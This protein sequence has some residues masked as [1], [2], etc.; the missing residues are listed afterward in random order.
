VRPPARGLQG[1]VDA[2]WRLLPPCAL[3][4]VRSG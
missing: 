2:W 4:T 3:P 1:C